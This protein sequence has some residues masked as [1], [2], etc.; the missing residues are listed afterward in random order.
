MLKAIIFRCFAVNALRQWYYSVGQA[1]SMKWTHIRW[2]L[3]LH[4]VF[5]KPFFFKAEFVFLKPAQVC[6]CLFDT[7]SQIKCLHEL[8]RAL[9]TFVWRIIL[10]QTQ[11]KRPKLH[12]SLSKQKHSLFL[13]NQARPTPNLV[14]HGLFS[15]VNHGKNLCHWLMGL[16]FGLNNG[17]I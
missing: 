14:N 8:T 12:F 7:V 4:T 6:I 16:G 17:L 2:M 10:S 1:K 13:S 15:K 5:L 9:Y 11:I 3:I